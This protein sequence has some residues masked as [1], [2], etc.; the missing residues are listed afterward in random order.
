P[1][2]LPAFDSPNAIATRGPETPSLGAVRVPAPEATG[3][4]VPTG[5]PLTSMVWNQTPLASSQVTAQKYEVVGGKPIAPLTSL[6]GSV[7]SP[8]KETWHGIVGMPLVPPSLLVVAP[9]PEPPEFVP[10]LPPVLA[11]ALPPVPIEEVV[12]LV[13]VEPPSPVIPPLV[14]TV[15]M[16]V[17]A[18]APVAP[19]TV[20]VALPELLF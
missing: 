16:P 11:P 15:L 10:T 13:L 12:V 4:G 14:P 1:M 3:K 7:I 5:L 17:S 2:V 6:L 20:V 18:P 19:P 9:P 8:V